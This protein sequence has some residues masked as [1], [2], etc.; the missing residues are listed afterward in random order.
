M[1]RKML[2]T[3]VMLL[4]TIPAV[5]A[6]LVIVWIRDTTPT[7][8]KLAIKAKLEDITGSDISAADIPDYWRIADQADTGKLLAIDSRRINF[9]KAQALQWCS[10]HLSVG[11]ETNVLW[12]AGPN[13]AIV[14]AYLEPVTNAVVR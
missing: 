9:T 6:G 5:Y 11:W 10:N 8:D 7:A 1:K 3:C 4:L 14:R 13:R 2:I 12:Y